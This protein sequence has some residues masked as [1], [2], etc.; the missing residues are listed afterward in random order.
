MT[1]LDDKYSNLDSSIMIVPSIGNYN[2]EYL[3]SPDDMF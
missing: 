2:C 3:E 1:L